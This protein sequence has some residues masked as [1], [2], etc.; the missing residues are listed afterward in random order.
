MFVIEQFGKL[1]NSIADGLSDSKINQ[2]QPKEL[3]RIIFWIESNWLKCIFKSENRSIDLRKQEAIVN[4]QHT[5]TRISIK[6]KQKSTF[7]IQ[8]CAANGMSICKIIS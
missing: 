1:L 5:M 7:E 2:A 6:D 4:D 3:L 8:K